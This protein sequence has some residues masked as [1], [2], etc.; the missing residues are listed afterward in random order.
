MVASAFFVSAPTVRFLRAL[1]RLRFLPAADRQKIASRVRAEIVPL[2]GCPDLDALGRASRRAQDERWRLISAGTRDATDVRLAGVVLTEQWL[3][4]H[5][6]L[7]R[8]AAP[9]AEVLAEKRRDA[10]EAFVRD[11]LYAE[12]GEVVDLHP[13]VSSGPHDQ[14]AAKTAA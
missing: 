7:M 6:E 8:A 14:D 11:N 4:A 13:Y 3:L 10:I 9:I 12:S 2:V 1:D 5:A